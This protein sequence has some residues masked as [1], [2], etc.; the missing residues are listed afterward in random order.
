MKIISSMSCTTSSVFGSSLSVS[1]AV[2]QAAMPEV[3]LRQM[4]RMLVFV[5]LKSW[6]VSGWVLELFQSVPRAGMQSSSVA[7]SKFLKKI[8]RTLIYAGAMTAVRF[9]ES[10]TRLCPFSSLRIS[11]CR[12]VQAVVASSE[13]A[14]TVNIIFFIRHSI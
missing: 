1:S 14:S 8:S 10:L 11:S 13:A 5:A 2:L 12:L 3:V 6:S 4:Y 7:S 9:D